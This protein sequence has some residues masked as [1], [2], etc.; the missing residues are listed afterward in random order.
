MATANTHMATATTL[1]TVPCT[2]AAGGGASAGAVAAAAS[3]ATNR[4]VNSYI[5]Q[6]VIWRELRLLAADATAVGV[7][8]WRR[9]GATLQFAA[10][11]HPVLRYKVFCAVTH[12]RNV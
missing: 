1:E 8:C 6:F 12:S 11:L 2:V 7:S 3:S 10:I 5:H 4:T 9:C